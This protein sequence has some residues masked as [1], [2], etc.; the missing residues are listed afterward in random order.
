MHLLCC[1]RNR[2]KR[3]CGSLPAAP[4]ARGHRCPF[5]KHGCSNL[6][7]GTQLSADKSIGGCECDGTI[8]RRSTAAVGCMHTCPLIQP[9]SLPKPCYSSSTAQWISARICRTEGHWFGGFWAMTSC[10]CCRHATGCSGQNGRLCCDHSTRGAQA[11]RAMAR[12]PTRHTRSIRTQGLEQAPL[13]TG[14]SALGSA[15]N[16]ALALAPLGCNRPDAM[17]SRHWGAGCA[18]MQAM[19]RNRLALGWQLLLALLHARRKSAPFH[20]VGSR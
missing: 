20:K 13:Y 18:G 2:T 9:C 14:D 6:K 10:P 15:A 3:L 16:D 5:S 1:R 17:S 4:F 12:R 19:L 7:H 11:C 8:P